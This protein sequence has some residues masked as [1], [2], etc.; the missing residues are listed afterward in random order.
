MS[1]KD[2]LTEELDRIPTTKEYADELEKIQSIDR[3]YEGYDEALSISSD[4]N[5][6]TYDLPSNISE[7][8]NLPK[9]YIENFDNKE[10]AYQIYEDT[11]E[12]LQ[13]ADE[14]MSKILNKEMTSEWAEDIDEDRKS[15]GDIPEGDEDY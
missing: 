5:S 1:I 15:R 12:K 6:D 14:I 10:E 11:Q 9:D 3:V 2:T 8:K 4:I 7:S 13:E